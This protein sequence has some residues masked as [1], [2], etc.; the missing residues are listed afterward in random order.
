MLQ[1]RGPQQQLR[2]SHERNY[3]LMAGHR[4]YASLPQSMVPIKEDRHDIRVDQQSVH[5]QVLWGAGLWLRSSRIM[6][7]KASTSDGSLSSDGPKSHSGGLSPGIEASGSGRLPGSTTFATCIDA[8][9]LSPFTC[10]LAVLRAS[11]RSGRSSD[12]QFVTTPCPKCPYSRWTCFP[13]GPAGSKA[14]SLHLGA[15]RIFRL[16]ECAAAR[17]GGA[18]HCHGIAIHWLSR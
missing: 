2:P 13:A 4:I 18:E 7:L 10:P 17:D 14:G 1:P 12:D 5:P 11:R 9:A 8:A 16:R 15:E 3:Q 6:W